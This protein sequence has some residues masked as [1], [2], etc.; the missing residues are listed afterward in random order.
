VLIYAGIC[1]G[2]LEQKS[3]TIMT[4]IQGKGVNIVIVM[5]SCS[6][7][8]GSISSPCEFK[9]ELKHIERCIPISQPCSPT[10]SPF[11]TIFASYSPINVNSFF[12]ITNTS[13]GCHMKVRINHEIPPN[14]II[15]P[16]DSVAFQVSNVILIEISCIGSCLELCTGTFHG[17]FFFSIPV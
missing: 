17:D 7:S 11:E 14:A 10:G 13:T 6:S 8:H 5:P 4:N 2:Q 9:R 1:I 15:H 16:G 12:T 3:H